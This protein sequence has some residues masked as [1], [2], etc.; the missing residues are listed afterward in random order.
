ME[1]ILSNRVIIEAE[2]RRTLNAPSTPQVKALG[3]ICLDEG[4]ETKYRSVNMTLVREGALLIDWACLHH[5][6]LSPNEEYKTARAHLTL[7]ISSGASA[8]KYHLEKAK[9]LYKSCLQQ[10]E[11]HNDIDV[12]QD[13]S[14]VLFHLSEIADAVN[15][16]EG[17]LK[18][19]RFAS[20]EKKSICTLLVAIMKFSLD[21]YEEAGG[22]FH[23]CLRLGPPSPFSV[24][25]VFFLIA[26]TV[27]RL[28]KERGL[29]SDD[30]NDVI[31]A[32]YH[33]AF[34][35][36]ND[37][38]NDNNDT[39]TSNNSLFRQWLNDHR[40]WY[41][42]A[43]KTVY[44]RSGR[45]AEGVAALKQ[46]LIECPDDTKY[47][48]A[49]VHWTHPT[50]SFESL[51]QGPLRD[52]L[53]ILPQQENVQALALARV[54]AYIRG[55]LLRRQLATGWRRRK[56]LRKGIIV[57]DIHAIL[58]RIETDLAGCV[59]EISLHDVLGKDSG[60]LR[61]S[62]PF[63]PSKIKGLPA[64]SNFT[65]TCTKDLV[66]YG[67]LPARMTAD[68]A[69]DEDM[70][71]T[72]VEVHSLKL[73]YEG[74]SEDEV[75]S[76]TVKLAFLEQMQ[77]DNDN[78]N[79]NNNNNNTSTASAVNLESNGSKL[80][81]LNYVSIDD[82][83]AVST[84]CIRAVVAKGGFR[85]AGHLFM[86]SIEN[87]Q[88]ITV[89]GL[90]HPLTA[91]R[92]DFHFTREHLGWSVYIPALLR[93]VFS[94]VEKYEVLWDILLA[95]VDADVEGDRLRYG[96]IVDDNMV[97]LDTVMDVCG[98]I[99]RVQSGNGRPLLTSRFEIVPAVDQASCHKV[100]FDELVCISERAKAHSAKLDA[101]AERRFETF[102]HLR[103]LARKQLQHLSVEER[104]KRA[105]LVQ[106]TRMETFS[107][108][109]D[110][111]ST[112]RIHCHERRVADC[113]VYLR[114]TAERAK[115]YLI[116]SST[117]QTNLKIQRTHF[118]LC[119]LA[120]RYET[121]VDI[122]RSTAIIKRE[123]TE[124]VLGVLATR[125]SA[126]IFLKNMGEIAQD[127]KLAVSY[128]FEPILDA[129]E[130][131]VIRELEEERIERERV[132]RATEALSEVV[133]DLFLEKTIEETLKECA[134]T[135][136]DMRAS[137]IQSLSRTMLETVFA[138]GMKDEYLRRVHLIQTLAR[139]SVNTVC[140]QGVDEMTTL[141]LDVALDTA[142]TCTE[143]NIDKSIS[144]IIT[145]REWLSLEIAS[146]VQSCAV[147][148]A[149]ES[150]MDEAKYDI[151]EELGEEA[152]R[153]EMEREETLQRA[154]W[155]ELHNIAEE[156]RQAAAAAAAARR[157]LNPKPS[158]KIL[159]PQ[160]SGRW[161]TRMF[162]EHQ[163]KRMEAVDY[164][165]QRSA[166]ATLLV[167]RAAAFE[168]LIRRAEG[169]LHHLE[170]ASSLEEKSHSQSG[171]M[172][173]KKAIKDLSNRRRSFFEQQKT[174]QSLSK[175][176]LLDTDSG[177]MSPGA[178]LSV[179]R[180]T[181]F[182]M[183][184]QEVEKRLPA[185]DRKISMTRMK[186]RGEDEPRK[187]PTDALTSPEELLELL[188][189]T[190]GSAKGPESIPLASYSTLTLSLSQSA[191]GE[192][193]L[194]APRRVDDSASIIAPKKNI[195]HK[196][197]VRF[198][199]GTMS[200]V[201]S[202]GKDG[203]QESLG[204]FKR[205]GYTH[206]ECDFTS[207]WERKIQD[208]INETA[209]ASLLGRIIS[210]L[211]HSHSETVSPAE[212]LC[213]LAD[214]GNC[215]SEAIGRLSDPTFREEVRLVCCMLPVEDMLEGV[216]CQHQQHSHAH[217]A[218]R[219]RG[220]DVHN[221]SSLS[222]SSPP[223]HSGGFP[224]IRPYKMSAAVRKRA[225]VVPVSAST[226]THTY[227]PTHRRSTSD[228][229]DSSKHSSSPMSHSQ[230]YLPAISASPEGAVSKRSILLDETVASLFAR[231]SSVTVI[232]TRDAEKAKAEERFS[233]SDKY[234]KIQAKK[235][236][237]KTMQGMRSAP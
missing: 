135:T 78:D 88:N 211:Q 147:A 37:N 220:E 185:A 170:V 48:Q 184:L 64:A 93:T 55:Y 95:Q 232:S 145:L 8:E 227:T 32:A 7:W 197:P 99:V 183:L 106:T 148:A 36:D 200:P 18:K 134:M 132:A 153:V 193:V 50:H 190:S 4:N 187:K 90:F 128:L 17:L 140:T 181:S 5:T 91:R 86:Y 23:Q 119:T 236:A 127:E 53:K 162:L 206:G 129:V 85:H 174:M 195:P 142:T 72:Q 25:D 216:P 69:V 62:A 143:T 10:A 15:I 96:T 164:L 89:I 226:P 179:Q 137:V 126:H 13:Y 1:S 118:E 116:L 163:T 19:D 63:S 73:Q 230:P 209:S 146:V 141:T 114:H 202:P 46:G 207:Q 45:L 182:A 80:S 210:K 56:V 159:V 9:A 150:F 109:Q 165:I 20:K 120:R 43:D 235:R 205:F 84:P 194:L 138:T 75:T 49:L 224:L 121:Y 123:Q 173:S 144:A 157:D 168:Y 115:V 76:L 196:D 67:E 171:Q 27:E 28:N 218:P 108:L 214:T 44:A 131:R 33:K 79:S 21:E 66:E 29:S 223:Q 68:M 112:A 35:F 189:V 16:L 54:Q 156:R 161:R 176:R 22:Y 58:I 101:V 178:P 71:G 94:F 2:L 217:S 97:L 177:S 57:N 180:Q 6:Q 41:L 186:P 47:S 82:S 70:M 152:R 158:H 92:L 52:I 83:A 12:L 14:K 87:V 221:T 192:S 38:D 81:V 30:E 74:S 203:Y 160:G 110:T 31:T 149:C 229:R 59:R 40:T 103:R 188:G 222:T 100:V 213:A 136:V 34:P 117:A 139:E 219:L 225:F 169:A 155:K 191:I 154:V 231:T 212:A 26:F 65:L 201:G 111:V 175:R 199:S 215:L 204:D 172:G 11:Y 105:K 124:R 3:L 237:A 208:C 24:R 102:E 51:V 228:M 151:G 234:K 98:G 167:T 104:E 133:M 77:S 125:M 61:L 166:Q 39:T 233:K 113:T 60:V 130:V 122:R 198:M 107:L 42:I